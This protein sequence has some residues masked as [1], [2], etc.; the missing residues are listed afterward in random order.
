MSID[1][2]LH[3]FAERSPST[4]SSKSEYNAEKIAKQR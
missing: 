4:S 3:E 1:C 2:V